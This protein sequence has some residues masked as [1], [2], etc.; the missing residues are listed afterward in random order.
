VTSSPDDEPFVVRAKLAAS[1]GTESRSFPMPFTFSLPN[2]LSR[3]TT[4]IEAVEHA[5]SAAAA[6]AAAHPF[7]NQ[8]DDEAARHAAEE[9]LDSLS[10]SRY[11]DALEPGSHDLEAMS[12]SRVERSRRCHPED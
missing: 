5:R 11:G 2:P 12:L 1:V 3:L 4:L 9:Q 7:A 8:A 6:E 10:L